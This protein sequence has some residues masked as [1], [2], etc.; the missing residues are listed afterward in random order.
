MKTKIFFLLVSVLLPGNSYSQQ[1]EYLV[2]EFKYHNASVFS[3]AFSPDGNYLISGGDDK[4]LVIVN[5]KTM[6]VENKYSNNYYSP[7]CIEVTKSN[8]IYF[9]T[10][11]DIKLIDLKNNKLA[12]FEGNT[13]QIWSLDYA[14]LNRKIAAGSFDYKVRVWDCT[15]QKIDRVLEGHKKSVLAVAF[16]PDEKYIVTGSLDKT[17][18]IWNTETGK[19]IKSLEKHADKIYAVKFH[20]SG[21]YF[22]SC[23][24]D[25]TIKLW[26]FESGEVLKTYFGHDYGVLDIEFTPDGNHLISASL[27]GT[28]RLWQIK[29]GNTVYTFTG[30]TGA[31]NTISINSDGSLMASGDVDNK[32]IL[33]KLDKKIFVEYA[34]ADELDAEKNKSDLFLPRQKNEKKEEYNDRMKNAKELEDQIVGKYYQKYVEALNSQTFK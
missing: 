28:I 31:V 15:T 10:G 5:L 20:P 2:K 11:P 3:V 24:N 22:A 19:M 27:D 30:H 1:D 6:T 26:D 25:K 23:S 4:L 13:T 12:L 9:G 34:F 14:P 16:S 32:V 18:K 21:K 17:V 8:D 7:F 29:S 33:W